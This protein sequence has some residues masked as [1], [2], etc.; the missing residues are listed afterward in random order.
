MDEIQM[1]YEN[2]IYY[3]SEYFT[4]PSDDKRFTNYSIDFRKEGKE[5]YPK[6]KIVDINGILLNHPSISAA[7]PT[8]N[9]C[10][11][12]GPSVMSSGA[13][14]LETHILVSIKPSLKGL[15]KMLIIAQTIAEYSNIN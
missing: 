6:P 12:L 15:S 11:E 14:I 2:Q 10:F 9:I 1:K 3:L 8:F 13:N 4:S 7:C 5:E